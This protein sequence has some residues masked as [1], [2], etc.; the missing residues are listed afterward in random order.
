MGLTCIRLRQERSLLMIEYVLEKLFEHNNWGNFQ[1]LQACSS[2]TPEQLDASPVSTTKGTIRE[3]LL[4]IAGA[5]EGYL[6]DLIGEDYESHWT[7]APGFDE[8][9]GSVTST[10]EALLALARDPGFAWVGRQLLT[11]DGLYRVEPW[12]VAVQIVNHA[13]EHREQV[14]SMLSTL[15]ITPPRID[16]WAY[17]RLNHALTPVST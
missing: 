9:I 13:T 2:L 17:G 6:S 8:L 3:T 7:D 4:H 16:G 1:I 14:K 12:V 11:R 15:G 10:G 5:Q